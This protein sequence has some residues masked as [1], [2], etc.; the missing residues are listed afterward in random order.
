MARV[1]HIRALWFN[2]YRW[3]SRG[4]ALNQM[5]YSII[6]TAHFGV[7][8]CETKISI[9]PPSSRRSVCILCVDLCSTENLFPPLRLL[10]VRLTTDLTVYRKECTALMGSS[11]LDNFLQ[12]K[13][14]STSSLLPAPGTHFAQGIGQVIDHI[15]ERF[16]QYPVCILTNGTLF[17]LNLFRA[18]TEGRSDNSIPGCGH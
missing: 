17:P 12:S 9:W 3:H 1:S 13:P 2:L 8:H 5:E 14:G 15:K 4:V 16:P 10:R 18:Q 6:V 7:D 11:E